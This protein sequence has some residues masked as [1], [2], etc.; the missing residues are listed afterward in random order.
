LA[1]IA[2]FVSKFGIG[3]YL[4]PVTFR[5]LAHAGLEIGINLLDLWFNCQ[6]ILFADSSP[7]QI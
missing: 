4:L 5:K 6:K 2:E 1:H 7:S 3:I